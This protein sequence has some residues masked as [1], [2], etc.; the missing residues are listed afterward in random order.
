[1]MFVLKNSKGEYLV[2]E[3]TSYD[4]SL[5]FLDMK[6]I[7]DSYNIVVFTQLETLPE[8]LKNWRESTGDNGIIAVSLVEGSVIPE[9]LA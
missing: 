7:D 8:L 3:D 4:D 2:E 1:M 9:A 5:I 6:M